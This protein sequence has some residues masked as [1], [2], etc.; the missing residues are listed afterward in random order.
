MFLYICCELLGHLDVIIV[1][2]YQYIN[3]QEISSVLAT[4]IRRQ[5]LEALACSF[6]SLYNELA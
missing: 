5:V 3:V 2:I 4:T 1:L 6:S